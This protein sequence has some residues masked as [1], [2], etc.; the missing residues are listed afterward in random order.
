[1]D[2][3]EPIQISLAPRLSDAD[4]ALAV[5]YLLSPRSLSAEERVRV[6]DVFDGLGGKPHHHWREN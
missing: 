1:M 3:V 4:R 2:K 6:L 5:R